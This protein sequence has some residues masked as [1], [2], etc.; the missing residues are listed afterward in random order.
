V[1]AT[2]TLDPVAAEDAGPAG[3]RGWLVALLVAA[4]VA[5]AGGGVV[6]LRSRRSG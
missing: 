2:P 5:A 6:L 4:L 3:G 1:T